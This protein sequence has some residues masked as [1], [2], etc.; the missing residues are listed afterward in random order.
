VRLETTIRDAWGVFGFLIS[1]AGA[2]ALFEIAGLSLWQLQI[3]DYAGH[4][5]LAVTGSEFA[6]MCAHFTTAAL[7]VV[8]LPTILLGAAFPAALRLTAGVEQ[9]GRDVG[10]VLAFNTAGG[11]AGTLLTGF[12]L[13]AVLGIIRSL[14]LLAIAAASVGTL[15]VLLGTWVTG[16][17]GLE[18]YANQAKPVTD[19]RPRIE[20]AAWVRPKE[21]TRALPDL[22]ALRTD[23]LTDAGDSF[24]AEVIRERG[25]LLF[26]AGLATYKGNREEWAEAIGR[27]M[28]SDGT[29]RYYRWI[30]GGGG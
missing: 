5:A 9:A 26:F 1:A 21:V 19:D 8:F 3:Q 14:G 7:G 10:S 12:L 2:I 23:P 29:N 16:R 4:M 17:E 30:A 20:Y 24:S 13:I 6:R 18:R 22:L 11:I 15:A 25:N 28:A 27:V